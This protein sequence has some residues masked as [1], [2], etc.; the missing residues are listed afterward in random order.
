MADISL[1]GAA[2]VSGCL[3]FLTHLVKIA[4]AYTFK[5]R[6]TRHKLNLEHEFEQRRKLS[7]LI[8]RHHG[9]LLYASNSLH[10]RF[11][12]LYQ[13]YDKKWLL[14]END[15]K[16]G[17]HYYIT[18][19]VY[20]FL[21][22]C[23]LIRAFERESLY[24]D[25]RYAEDRHF[26]FLRFTEALRW[27]VSDVALF[28][29]LPYDDNHP[30]DHFYADTFRHICDVFGGHIENA[31]G[32]EDFREVVGK[33]GSFE[34]VF[35]FFE[36]LERDEARLRWDRLVCFHIILVAFIDR[37]G[38]KNHKISGEQLREIV[39]QIRHRE[40]LDNLLV[41]LPRHGL[42]DKTLKSIV[43]ALKNPS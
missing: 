13:N 6:E 31:T 25:T 27:C 9:Q 12:N 8:S 43:A 18:S 14:I 40:I 15:A 16:W 32:F 20:R 22:V 4:L 30:K 3:I 35:R 42:D 19:F 38:Y 17:D 21:H 7:T 11:L 29:D 28:Q 34:S 10:Y 33:N 26:E 24:I 36:G 1:L 2:V 37:I 5:R 23:W 39:K 41:W